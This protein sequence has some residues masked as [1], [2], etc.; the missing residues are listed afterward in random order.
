MNRLHIKPGHIYFRKPFPTSTLTHASTVNYH[1]TMIVRQI[2]FDWFEEIGEATR[3]NDVSGT[4]DEE[5]IDI[6]DTDNEEELIDAS[7]SEENLRVD[8]LNHNSD[9]NNKED[10]GVVNYFGQQCDNCRWI[11]SQ[12]LII[13]YGRTHYSLNLNECNRDE[14]IGRQK[15]QTVKLTRT[16]P[17]T[18]LLCSQCTTYITEKKG[19]LTNICGL[20]LYGVY[21]SIRRFNNSIT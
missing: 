3:G 2:N 6:H 14:L 21:S 18:Y 17:E 7:L 15:F 19:M 9:D 8:N 1:L 5:S 11:E 20:V 12:V 13:E 4:D 16:D 10:D